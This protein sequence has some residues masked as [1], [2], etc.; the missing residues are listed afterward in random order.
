MSMMSEQAPDAGALSSTVETNTAKHKVKKRLIAI[1]QVRKIIKRDKR[2]NLLCT[3]AKHLS[4]TH[5]LRISF[6]VLMCIDT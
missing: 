1:Y 5:G 2:T 3:Y 4:W 6:R